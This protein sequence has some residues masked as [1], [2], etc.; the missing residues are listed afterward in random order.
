MGQGPVE[1]VSKIVHR[2]CC[3][4]FRLL[5]GRGRCG[6]NVLQFFIGQVRFLF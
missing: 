5:P 6:M 1:R 3:F 4:R 2:S